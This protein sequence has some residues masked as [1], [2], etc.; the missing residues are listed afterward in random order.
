MFSGLRLRL[1]VLYLLVALALIALVGGGT[2]SLLG[3]YFQTSTDLAMRYRIAQEFQ[4]YGA[5]LPSDLADAERSWTSSY[6]SLIPTTSR[7]PLPT[8]RSGEDDHEHESQ[9]SDS[10]HVDS[11]DS[12]IAA[13]FVTAL[14]ARG[15]ALTQTQTFA[16]AQAVSRD[17]AVSALGAGSDVRTARLNSGER[18]R[19]ITYR[20]SG[21]GPP[22]LQAGRTL[23]DQDRVLRQLLIGLLV[24]GSA[25]AVALGVCSWWLAERSLRPAQEAWERQQSFV[26]NASHE[27]RAPLTLLRASAEVALRGM[28]HSDPDN[29]ALLEDVL[30]ETDH[31]NRLVGDLLLLSRIDAGRLKVERTRIDLS[32]LVSDVQR[33]VGRLANERG[34]RLSASGL[35]GVILGDPTRVRQVLIIL[36]DN[37]LRHTP[38]GG[39]VEIATQPHGRQ[40]DV[41]VSDTGLG[42]APEHLPHVFER[43]YRGESVRGAEGSGSGLGLSIAK[44]LVE[45]QGGQI[46]IDSRLGQGTRVTLKLP[47]AE[48]APAT[49][50]L[51]SG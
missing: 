35:A 3:Y 45:A 31:M 33:Q 44:A 14:D 24:L 15:Q 30:N 34:V 18:V 39:A 51:A 13:I 12:Q 16:P 21:S 6:A 49:K 38:R 43:F 47:A 11:Y 22:L 36:L 32:D 42:I 10:Q 48:V 2:Y 1:T 4:R 25:S 19:L 23:S 20:L 7:A 40:V 46:A 50:A 17:A 28:S 27:L 5:A 37:A 26:A 9:P 8:R 41:T 29:R